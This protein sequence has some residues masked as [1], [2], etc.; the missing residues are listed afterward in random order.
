MN[1]LLIRT[2]EYRHAIQRLSI[3]FILFP[4][5]KLKNKL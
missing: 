3:D 2:K 5:N 1:E 4:F